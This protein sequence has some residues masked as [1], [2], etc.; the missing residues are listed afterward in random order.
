MIN[1]EIYFTECEDGYYGDICKNTCGQCLK[2][3]KTCD[4]T[5]GH[6]PGGCSAGWTDDTCQTGTI[7]VNKIMCDFLRSLFLFV[8]DGGGGLITY[9]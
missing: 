8:V 9:Y 2:G 4:K 7:A 6:C 1:S 5:T 3:N